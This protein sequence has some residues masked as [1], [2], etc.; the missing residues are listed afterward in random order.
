M[1]KIVKQFRSLSLSKK[2]EKEE[3]EEDDP[4]SSESKKKIEFDEGWFSDLPLEV[5]QSIKDAA[6]AIQVHFSSLLCVSFLSQR[7]K[8]SG[9]NGFF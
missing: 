6:V 3:E 7:K 5:R 1:K 8:Y 4:N 2:E 9:K